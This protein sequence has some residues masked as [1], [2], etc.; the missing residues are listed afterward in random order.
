VILDASAILAFLFRET[1]AEK[2][3]A[4][5]NGSL[6]SSINWSEVLGRF[7]RL[8]LPI[9]TVD[10]QLCNVGCRLVGFHRKHALIAAELLPVTAHL[11]LSLGDRAC[12]ALGI[13]TG[14]PVL[15]ADKA[16]CTLSLG[17]DIR[18]IR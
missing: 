16:W 18:S 8:G 1:G 13:D 6:V 10:A 7:A 14:L 2:V 4:H 17:L 11:G 12:L 5:L 15:T 3:T 9:E